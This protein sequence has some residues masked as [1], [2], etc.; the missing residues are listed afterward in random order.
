MFPLLYQFQTANYM[1]DQIVHDT[2]HRDIE[3]RVHCQSELRIRHLH[4]V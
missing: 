2:I 3:P 4:L 1:Q